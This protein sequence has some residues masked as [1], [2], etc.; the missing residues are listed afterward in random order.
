MAWSKRF[1][2]WLS[3]PE[4]KP[5]FLLEDVRITHKT[6]LLDTP[7]RG[8]LKLSS[9]D[10][11]AGYL[12][13]IA[14]DGSGFLGGAVEPRSW[15]ATSGA[16]S[17]PVVGKLRSIRVSLTR[18]TPV[19]LRVGAAGW[20]LQDYETIALG[21]LEDIRQG[22]AGLTLEV[23]DLLAALRT[24]LTT[25]PAAQSLF[26]NVVEH[27]VI[28]DYTA[29]DSALFITSTSSAFKMTDGTAGAVLVT[30]A[31][32]GDPF[33][34][35]FSGAASSTELTLTGG[36]VYNTTRV[37]AVSGSKVLLVAR[38]SAVTPIGVA[39]EVLSSTGTNGAN[40]V[41]DTC[42]IG[43]GYGI[44]NRWIDRKDAQ[45]FRTW[46]KVTGNNA[47]NT[48]VEG[49]Q[50]DGWSWLAD[51]IAYAGCFVTTRQGLLTVRAAMTG[52][53]QLT[54]DV[55]IV[56][57]HI[58]DAYPEDHSAWA[59]EAPVQYYQLF[60]ETSNG[61]DD[62]V[63]GEV[64]TLPVEY[65]HSLY[66]PQGVFNNE[67]NQRDG[68]LAR[69]KPF[70]CRIPERIVLVVKLRY[71]VL[72]PGDTCL[73]STSRIVGRHSKDLDGLDRAYVWVS[74]VDVDWWNGSVQLTLFQFP[75]KDGDL[76]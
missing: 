29:G 8:T 18:G 56:D 31:G 74:R 16:W 11:G 62:V 12:P 41:D 3:E 54:S 68:L 75:G 45:R 17:V 34:L 55:H 14:N 42:P 38:V 36:N 13:V 20:G 50:L 26:A 73:L 1:I 58:I 2:N 33:Y 28:S 71:A 30:P 15:S 70:Y 22:P 57:E 37:D 51:F 24:R 32:G 23:R 27:E 61:V 19:R 4:R 7:G 40:G 5:V 10:V 43:W 66:F 46:I 67:A 72:A 49:E 6:S 59:A 44:A 47:C 64:T 60:A 21:L 39:L 65:Q 35:L 9:A 63:T 69:L 76:P 52:R 53:R 25:S 48:A